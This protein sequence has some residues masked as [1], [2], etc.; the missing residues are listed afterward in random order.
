M[1]AQNNAPFIKQLHHRTDYIPEPDLKELVS[2]LSFQVN[3]PCWA[4][5]QKVFLLQFSVS[6]SDLYFSDVYL[7]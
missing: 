7:M 2:F 1:K 3:L 4:S 6:L 5:V